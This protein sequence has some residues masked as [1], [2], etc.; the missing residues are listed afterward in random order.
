MFSL[1]N[2][3]DSLITLRSAKLFTDQPTQIS[4]TVRDQDDL[5][6]LLKQGIYPTSLI[7]EL[8]DVE[9]VDFS[10]FVNLKS[11][12]LTG[13]GEKVILPTTLETLV[14]DEAVVIKFSPSFEKLLKMKTLHIP[15]SS[16]E[17]YFDG[18]LPPNLTKLHVENEGWKK[19][20]PFPYP[21]PQSVTELWFTGY[22]DAEMYNQLP[23]TLTSLRPEILY[24]KINLA[25]FRHLTDLQLNYEDD[26]E[27]NNLYRELITLPLKS[28]ILFYDGDD[29]ESEIL[30]YLPKTLT[31]LTLWF[32]IDIDVNLDLSQLTQLR[33]LVIDHIWPS[34]QT[35]VVL[36]ASL[37][38]FSISSDVVTE[39]F[40]VDFS[41]VRELLVLRV[42]NRGK[43][44]ELRGLTPDMVKNLQDYHANR[45]HPLLRS[46]WS[47]QNLR[48]NEE[49]TGLD[50]RYPHVVRLELHSLSSE[51]TFPPNLQELKLEELTLTKSDLPQGLVRLKI[52]QLTLFPDYNFESKVWRNL[53]QDQVLMTVLDRERKTLT[54]I[55]QITALKNQG[56]V[57]NE[58]FLRAIIGATPMKTY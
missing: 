52:S 2:K 42:A 49:L 33:T 24:D 15:W 58:Y 19:P 12:T 29:L 25:Q 50:K 10:G 3:V 14:D 40:S 37:T 41:K 16:N 23:K 20:F 4:L 13:W 9:E 34:S 6:Q 45:A 1:V 47:I 17:E 39:N 54:Q 51:L 55:S 36:P 7:C 43:E 27:D 32:N 21:V 57:K 31:E 8:K 44:L 38:N 53:V 28:L 18:K 46:S 5:D 11:L 22:D 56:D 35:Q 30:P 48:L 26:I